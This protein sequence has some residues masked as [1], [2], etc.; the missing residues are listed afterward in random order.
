MIEQAE[1]QSKQYEQETENSKFSGFIGGEIGEMIKQYRIQPQYVDKMRTLRLPQFFVKS[2]P[3]MFGGDTILL[4]KDSLLEGFSLS[5]Q[6][7]QVNFSLSTGE[8]YTVD[9]QEQGDSVPKYRRVSQVES[10]FLH[11]LFAQMAQEEK[12]ESCTKSICHEIWRNNAFSTSEIEDYVRRIVKNITEDELVA[13]ET[14]FLIYARKIEEKIESLQKQYCEKQFYQWLDKGLILCQENYA[15][16]EIIT[17]QRTNSSVPLSLYE[18][19][20]YD[21]NGFENKLHCW[22]R[23]CRMVA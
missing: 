10:N 4:E 20:F 13:M 8:T 7:A 21:T 2:T 6:D 17:P 19:E 9:V 22:D 16:P 18:A 23:F 5:G 15:F 14:S 1:K 12:I 11:D 3:D